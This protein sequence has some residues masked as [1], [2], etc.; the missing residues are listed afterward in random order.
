MNRLDLHLITPPDRL[1]PAREAIGEAIL[2]LFRA[3]DADD[4]DEAAART[5]Q[6]LVDRLLDAAPAASTELLERRLLG[7]ARALEQLGVRVQPDELIA[8]AIPYG[9][10]LH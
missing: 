10:R 1:P 3:V 7:L 6:G 8:R 5:L 4:S 2:R 9:D